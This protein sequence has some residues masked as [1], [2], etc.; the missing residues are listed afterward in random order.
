MATVI[1]DIYSRMPSPKYVMAVGACASSGGAFSDQVSYV[2]AHPLDAIIPVDVYVPGCPP[3]PEA[4][5]D[6]LIQLQK[7]IRLKGVNE[8]T[9]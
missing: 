1:R 2:K 8:I 4:L 7:K 9:P 5:M 6:G 3:R